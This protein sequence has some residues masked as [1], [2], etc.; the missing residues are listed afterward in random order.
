MK[1]L[2][3]LAL[4]VLM[5]LSVALVGCATTNIDMTPKKLAILA[6]ETY[7]KQYDDYMSFFVKN[8]DGEWVVKQ[9]VSEDQ[10]EILR[11]RKNILMDLD[12][13]TDI[14]NTYIMIGYLPADE[15]IPAIETEIIKL[16]R[17]LED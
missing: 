15:T 2:N 7:V 9:G 4:L 8:A 3:Y 17:E 16:I 14:L 12:R 6:N 11:K 13:L 1:K 10:K 5:V